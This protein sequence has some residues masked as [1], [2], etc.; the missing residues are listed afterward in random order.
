VTGL[1]IADAGP[2]FGLA[3]IGRL[4]LLHRLYGV[5]ALPPAVHREL[6]LTEL[7]PTVP[8]LSAAIANGWLEVVRPAP[9]E[10]LRKLQLLLDPGEAEA[11]ELAA[12]RGCRFVLLDGRR[13]RA[14]ARR[15]NVPVAGTG[16]VLLAAK[17]GGHIDAIEPILK[18]LQAARSSLAPD[19][20]HALLQKAGEG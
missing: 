14:V 13:G 19:L 4:A 11:I 15:W 3:R 12:Q 1:V 9:S 7:R 17:A 6:R 8:P 2:L 5:V 20:V 16:A 10:G 18:E